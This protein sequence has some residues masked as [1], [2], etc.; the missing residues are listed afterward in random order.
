MLLLCVIHILSLLI[1]LINTNMKLF[2]T[3]IY[4]GRNANHILK[5]F[6]F[7]FELMCICSSPESVL[8]WMGSQSAAAPIRG[9]T[10]SASSFRSNGTWTS[11]LTASLYP[12]PPPSW[13]RRS[14][15]VRDLLNVNITE[16]KRRTT[17]LE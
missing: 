12:T 7:P 2:T 15:Q 11:T 4:Q 8:E 17:L 1:F 9:I 5:R 14:P 6:V 16:G 13:C 10:P 3:E